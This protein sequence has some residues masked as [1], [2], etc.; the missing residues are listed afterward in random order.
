MDTY[1]VVTN[2]FVDVFPPCEKCRTCAHGSSTAVAGGAPTSFEGG[3]GRAVLSA[4]ATKAD[5][6][7]KPPTFLRTQNGVGDV[8]ARLD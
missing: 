8:L 2:R 4:M 1:P 3:L 6:A 5:G 7:L